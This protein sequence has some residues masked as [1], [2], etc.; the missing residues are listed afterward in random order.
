MRENLASIKKAFLPVFLFAALLFSSCSKSELDDLQPVNN[1][2]A[3][4]NT[5]ADIGNPTPGVPLNAMINISH[6][7]CMGTC[8]YYIV[9]VSSE[10]DVVYN[11]IQNVATRGIVRYKI[12]A[13]EAK[14]LAYMMVQEGFFKLDNEYAMIPDAQRFETSL[15]WEGNSKTV[16]DYGINIPY[17]LISMRQKV[18][19]ALKIEKLVNGNGYID[20]PVH[21]E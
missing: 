15:V 2:S 6:G 13:E 4:T 8:P 1:E 14:Q 11:G 10:G 17:N 9:T 19:H 18:E 7:L 20:D 3:G 21:T 5:T 12:S 16:V